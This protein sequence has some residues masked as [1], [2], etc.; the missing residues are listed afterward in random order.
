[1]LCKLL[2]TECHSGEQIRRLRWIGMQHVW[3]T[4]EVHTKFCWGD[5]AERDHLEVLGVDGRILLQ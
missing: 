4:E 1:M 2:L 3:D 5:L